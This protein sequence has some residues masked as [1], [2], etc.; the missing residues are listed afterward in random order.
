MAAVA[1]FRD[2]TTDGFQGDVLPVNEQLATIDTNTRWPD[3]L[4]RRLIAAHIPLSVLNAAVDGNRILQDSFP[5]LPF[6]PRGISRFR[7]DAVAQAGVG[8]V[9]V[10]F[11]T[12]EGQTTRFRIESARCCIPTLVDATVAHFSRNWPKRAR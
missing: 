5:G 7:R 10:L 6:G 3:D 12:G 11:A 1:T 2:S 4:Q 9:I 8:D